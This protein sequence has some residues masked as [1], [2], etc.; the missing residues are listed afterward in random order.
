MEKINPN[1]LQT[2]YLT[3]CSQD[4]G[5]VAYRRKKEELQTDS[6]L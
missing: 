3:I 4:L 1:K 6:E 5:K 2:Q